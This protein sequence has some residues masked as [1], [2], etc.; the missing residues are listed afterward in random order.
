MHSAQPITGEQYA[1]CAGNYFAAAII[2]AIET[3]EENK[4]YYALASLMASNKS[5]ELMGFEK[6]NAIT[7]AV[8]EKYANLIAQDKDYMTPLVSGVGRCDKLGTKR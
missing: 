6:S 8:V 1:T 5:Y 7:R 3:N 2:S 4:I